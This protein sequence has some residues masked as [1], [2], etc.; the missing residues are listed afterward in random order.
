MVGFDEMP[1]VWYV[2]CGL[3]DNGYKRGCQDLWCVP[4]S[5]GIPLSIDDTIFQND[6]YFEKEK[7]KLE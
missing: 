6:E 2:G 1:D 5:E 4:K 3:D 7:Q